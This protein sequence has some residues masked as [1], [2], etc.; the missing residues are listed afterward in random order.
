[1][2]PSTLGCG[3][4]LSMGPLKVG[5]QLGKTALGEP[6]FG[7]VVTSGSQCD[8]SWVPQAVPVDGVA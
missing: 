3:V 4:H 8:R 5:R 7:K 6:G 1:M 2:C